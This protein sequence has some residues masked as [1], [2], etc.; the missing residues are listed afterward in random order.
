MIS[1][2]LSNIKKSYGENNVLKGISLTFN[3]G[4]G[5]IIGVIGKNGSGK[6]TLFKILAKI[7][8]SFIGELGIETKEQVRLGFLPEDRSLAKLG[9]IQDILTLWA[10]IQSVPAKKIQ[11]AVERWLVK[12]NLWSN[13]LD[14]ISSLSKGNQQKLQLACALIHE[15]N[16]IIFDEPFS[17]LDPNNQELVIEILSEFRNSGAL[18]FLSAHQ[19]ELVERIANQCFLLLDGNLEVIESSTENLQNELVIECYRPQ[20]LQGIPIAKY[21]GAFYFI[22]LDKISL[23]HKN[24]LL[25]LFSN[26][27]IKVAQTRSLRNIFL[28]KVQA[29]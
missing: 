18:I 25:D 21:K 29:G 22:E 19:L 1:I 2:S 9:N 12:T 8:K 10:R 13:R 14:K 3:C 7:D 4:K 17:G 28:Q 5:N 16:L 24:I 15:P 20:L 6:S 23:L 26:Q 11:K 27:E